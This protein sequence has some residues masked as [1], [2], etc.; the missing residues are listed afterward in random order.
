MPWGASW[1]SSSPRNGAYTAIS[2]AVTDIVAGRLSV[3]LA[4]LGGHL[5][6]I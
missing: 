1:R 2:Q 3:W 4:T 6:N 5:G